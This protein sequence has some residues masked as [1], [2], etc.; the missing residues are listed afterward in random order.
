MLTTHEILTALA[1]RGL[2]SDKDYSENQARRSQAEDE[3]VYAR[4]LARNGRGPD[5]HWGQHSED[6]RLLA[7]CEEIE[8]QI[9]ATVGEIGN[10]VPR[11]FSAKTDDPL[12]VKALQP[13]STRLSL[14]IETLARYATERAPQKRE[15][16][17]DEVQAVPSDAERPF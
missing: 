15:P 7:W 9:A 14:L 3:V 5:T 1:W 11:Y 8:K 17:P 12:D 2:Y 4:V 13:L 10:L 16:E 6:P